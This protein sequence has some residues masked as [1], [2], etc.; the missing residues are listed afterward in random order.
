MNRSA[1]VPV[2]DA[3]GHGPGSTP[4]ELPQVA[5]AFL[6]Q[7][8][9]VSLGAWAD[10]GRR[11]TE[12]DED[13]R[14]VLARTGSGADATVRA[15]LRRAVHAR[16]RVAAQ[17]RQRVTYLA[18]VAHGF[19]HPSDVARMK[20][21]ALAAVLALVVRDE[22]GEERFAAVY[23]PFA[24]LIPLAALPNAGVDVADPAPAR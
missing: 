24:A 23:E 22:L 19:V 5:L 11:L 8:R 4:G 12:L 17:A 16:P 20:K 6:E 10:A 14:R 9:R 3:D 15:V 1:S 21:A 2:V 7:L 18:A 13:E